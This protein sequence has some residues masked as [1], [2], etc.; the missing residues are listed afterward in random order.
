METPDEEM[1][2][3]ESGGQGTKHVRAQIPGAGGLS[4]SPPA[5][6]DA[7]PSTRTKALPIEEHIPELLR[8]VAGNRVVFVKGETG[9]GKSSMVPLCLYRDAV[10]RGRYSYIICTQPR[11]VAAIALANRVAHLLGEDVGQTV[12]YRIGG[13]TKKEC[14]GKTKILFV[15]TGYL[16]ESL[17]HQHQGGLW[18]RATHVVLDAKNTVFGLTRDE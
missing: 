6:S 2:S 8:Q 12:G 18:S 5:L 14:H 17:S 3:L 4:P 9:C 7:V 16:L 11:R 10:A 1:D 13:G 15:T